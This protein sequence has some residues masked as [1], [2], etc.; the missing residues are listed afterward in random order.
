MPRSIV[1]F[2]AAT[3][4][5]CALSSCSSG[6]HAAVPRTL[7]T[8]SPT[9]AAPSPTATATA[10]TPSP[11]ATPAPGKITGRVRLHD[12]V[13][14][15]LVAVTSVVYNV[16]F[17]SDCGQPHLRV[18]DS[19]GHVRLT[20]D[21]DWGCGDARPNRPA[22]DGTGNVFLYYN[23]GR[24]DGVIILR[25]AGG[26]IQDFD[27]LPPS[28][29]TKAADAKDDYEGSGPFGYYANTAPDPTAHGRLEIKQFTND[30]NPDCAGGRITSEIYR[31]DGQRYVRHRNQR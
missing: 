11:S 21:W 24:Y 29:N 3:F 23:P 15:D 5:L 10:K 2:L 8:Q 7:V 12:T 4:V 22:T 1:G 28:S 27:T 20:R 30:C 18:L 13:W 6:D 14:G 31:W 16:G 25:A 9:T 19:A 26:K 17:E